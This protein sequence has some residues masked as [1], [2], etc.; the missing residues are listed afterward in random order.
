MKIPVYADDLLIEFCCDQ[1]RL[2]HFLGSSNREIV[3][4]HKTGRI[5]RINVNPVGDDS[6]RRSRGNNHHPTY[7]ERPT[8]GKKI[9]VIKRHDRGTGQ[10]L[11]WTKKDVFTPGRF[12]PD[13]IGIAIIPANVATQ[14]EKQFQAKQPHP[15]DDRM[16][17]PADAP[18][19]PDA[20]FYVRRDRSLPWSEAN[21]VPVY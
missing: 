9:I 16:A 5:V 13:R 12:N 3:R 19:V 7:T 8:G 10:L 2:G 4:A 1:A 11:R 6:A 15:I 17:K 14:L 21:S 20:R 18:L